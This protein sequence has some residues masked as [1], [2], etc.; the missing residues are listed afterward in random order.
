MSF[1]SKKS[2]FL[3]LLKEIQ[4][5]PTIL[6]VVENQTSCWS[7]FFWISLSCFPFHFFG[8]C[9]CCCFWLLFFFK[10]SMFFQFVFHF[11]TPHFKDIFFMF[12]FLFFHWCAPLVF[13][14]VH[15]SFVFVNSVSL[16]FPLVHF[17]HCIASPTSF[18]LTDKRLQIKHVFGCFC[19]P[20]SLSRVLSLFFSFNFSILSLFVFLL[21]SHLLLNF[22]F[23]ILSMFF[24]CLN[25]SLLFFCVFRS[26]CFFFISRASSGNGHCNSVAWGKSHWY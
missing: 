23:F 21:F 16:H 5:N 7:F 22:S 8:F 2:H 15:F 9:C 6:R 26:L 20:F 13:R 18:F 14:F 19:V 3:N 1:F 4:T 25:S 24:C 11:T 10:F 17:F 12:S